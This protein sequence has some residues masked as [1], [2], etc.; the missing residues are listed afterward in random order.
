MTLTELQAATDAAFDRVRATP[1]WQTWR[2]LDQKLRDRRKLIEATNIFIRW[3]ADNGTT[4]VGAD[5]RPA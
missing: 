5:V 4:S 2:A 1:E 3:T